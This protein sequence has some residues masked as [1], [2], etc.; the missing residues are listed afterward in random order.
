M[1]IYSQCSC[2]QIPG[3]YI[4]ALSIVIQSAMIIISSS[5]GTEKAYV[6]ILLEEPASYLSHVP[7]MC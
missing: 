5:P 7:I 2:H 3:V 1:C 6:I 4:I